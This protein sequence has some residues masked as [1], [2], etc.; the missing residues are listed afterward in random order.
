M[1]TNQTIYFLL[2]LLGAIIMGFGSEWMQKEY[3]LSLGIVLLMFGVYKSSQSWRG[4]DK[5]EE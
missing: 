2:I 3:A 1:K 4:R 5:E